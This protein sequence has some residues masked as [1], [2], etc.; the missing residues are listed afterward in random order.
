MLKT[1]KLKSNFE[2]C[3]L[4][5]ESL[6]RFCL[7][8]L[9]Q[10]VRQHAGPQLLLVELF[11]ALFRRRHILY[12]NLL[13]CDAG[14][15]VLALEYGGLAGACYALLHVVERYYIAYM[16]VARTYRVAVIERASL[17]LNQTTRTQARHG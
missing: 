13:D 9:Q 2:F 14:S 8:I 5:F 11:D 15:L 6:S 17:A 1:Q 7:N 4:Y 16:L 3:I 10:R 12:G